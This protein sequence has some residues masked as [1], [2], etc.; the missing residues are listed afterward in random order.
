MSSKSLRRRLNLETL[1]NRQLFANDIFAVVNNG[2]LNL[3]E[4]NGSF[5]QAQAVE[6]SRP[7]TDP[8][9][10][11]IRVKGVANLSGGTTLINGATFRDFYVGSGNLNINLGNGDNTIT[12]KDAPINNLNVDTGTGRDKVIFDHSRT[13]GVTNLRTGAG[14]D[15]VNMIEA[16]MG[17]DAT[18]HM[19][20]FLDTG[21]DTFY[22]YNSNVPSEISGNLNVYMSRSN[23]DRDVDVISLTNAKVRGTLNMHT[24]AGDDIVEVRRVVVGNDVILNMGADADKAKF[25]EVQALDDFFAYMGAG[26]DTLEIDDVWADQMEL[27]G[28]PIETH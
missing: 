2:T 21:A 27:N 13:T 10:K 18:D 16:R 7:A 6:I 19:N 3:V 9:G 24:G 1:E 17:N 15:L 5:G 28:K 14:N 25:I 4:A 20:L 12:I 22:S 8:T 11:V 26:A 23:T